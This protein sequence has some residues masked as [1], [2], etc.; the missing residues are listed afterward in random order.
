MKEYNLNRHD[1]LTFMKHIYVDVNID[2]ITVRSKFVLQ[3]WGVWVQEGGG[4]HTRSKVVLCIIYF[5][6]KA[7]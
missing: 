5:P 3:D 2:V 4:G 1:N 6:K 7:C